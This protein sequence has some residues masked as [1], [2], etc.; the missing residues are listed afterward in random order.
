VIHVNTYS[1]SHAL[2]RRPTS[3]GAPKHPQSPVEDRPQRLIVSIR[4]FFG[5]SSMGFFRKAT[6]VATGGASGLFG[7]ANSKKERTANAT[8]KQVRL[9]KKQ[10]RL[11][12]DLARQATPKRTR[13]EPAS[14]PGAALPAELERLAALH[15]QGDL[16]DD[17]FQAAKARLIGPGRN[18]EREL[19][20]LGRKPNAL[21]SAEALS[22]PLAPTK[23]PA[24]AGSE[25]LLT[26]AVG[27]CTAPR[28]P[29]RSYCP[30][31]GPK[32]QKR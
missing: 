4:T 22:V 10:L 12:K 5:V 18:L 20:D 16:S 31:H 32:V 30:K 17:E 28:E 13:P 27:P 26:C 23:Q 7:R 6:F 1:V 2:P 15:R 14:D 8:E 29:G 24:A 3:P 25:I 11:E 21:R 19:V 9:Q